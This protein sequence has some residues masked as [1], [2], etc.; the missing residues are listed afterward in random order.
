MSDIEKYSRLE[1]VEFLEFLGRVAV[2]LYGQVAELSMNDKIEKVLVELFRL[3]GEKVRHPPKTNN[4]E[5]V[6]D[7]EDDLVQMAKKRVKEDNH[8]QFLIVDIT[9]KI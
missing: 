6:S 2:L 1:F 3:I 9:K 8:E 5:L 4:D 7:F